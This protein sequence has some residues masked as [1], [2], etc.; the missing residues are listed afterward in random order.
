MRTLLI[1]FL[2]FLLYGTT[3]AAPSIDASFGNIHLAFTVN[4]GQSP[5]SIRFTAQGSG[6][7]M[8]FSPAGT[9]F[10]LSRETAA[11]VAKRAAKKSV[12]FENDPTRDRPEYE[13]FALK[14]AFVG[15]NENPEIQGEDRLPWNNNYFI[16]NDPDQWR[17]DVP[18]YKK[19]RLREVYDGVDLVYYGNRKRVKYDFVVKPGEDPEKILLKYDF[20]EAGGALEVNEKGE[21]VVKTPVGELIEEKPYCYQ[22]IEG[23]EAAVEVAYEVIEGGTYR[24]RVGEY[25]KSAELVIDPELVYSTYLGG[26]EEDYVD[27]IAADSEGCAYVTG[28]TGSRDFPITAGAYDTS[29]HTL[30]VSKL[31]PEGTALLYSTYL[32]GPEPSHLSRIAVDSQGNACVTG[33]GTVGFPVTENAIDKVYNGGDGFITKIN[34]TGNGLIVSTFFGGSQ[35]DEIEAVA[36]DHNDNIYITGYTYSSDFPTTPEAYENENDHGGGEVVFV[37]KFNSDASEVLYSTFIGHGAATDIQVNSSGEVY[38]CGR[39]RLTSPDYPLTDNAIDTIP[40]SIGNDKIFITKLNETGSQLVYSTLLGGTEDQ[41]S[42]GIALD[43]SGSAYVCG[44]TTSVDF[45]TT[46][47]AFM[48]GSILSR[49]YGFVSKISSDGGKLEYSTLLTGEKDTTASTDT[50]IRDI[51]IYG[52]GYSV[53]TGRTG[54]RYF[55]VTP[56][57]IQPEKKG[58][59]SI[60]AIISKDGGNLIYSTYWGGSGNDEANALALDG[61]GNVYIAGITSSVDFPRSEGAIDTTLSRYDYLR[62]PEGFTSKFH[63]GDIST[64]VSGHGDTP[65]KFHIISTYPNPFNPSTTIEFSLPEPEKVNLMVYSITGQKVY[66]V[67][68]KKLSAGTQRIR[69]DGKDAFN[70]TVSSGIYLIRLDN[71]KRSIA[72][73]VLFLK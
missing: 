43:S 61:I 12:V 9:T 19:I 71:G 70:K 45:P 67:Q 29:F 35:T 23:K 6:C 65:S 53:I 27:D 68:T 51:A 52:D 15:A 59:N 50:V 32:G 20:G 73:K 64:H 63:F 8:A 16:G 36:L 17:T 56:D 47:N 37:T 46:P 14:L 48:T 40:S 11:S 57:A 69:W 2:G 72:Q 58:G 55:P 39:T 7:G 1:A 3:L 24:F 4:R 33:E 31:N 26:I 41:A 13:S 28:I 60:L 30:F 10:L 38:I 54:A 21:L 22:K 49:Y 18:N 44:T 66:E 25:D 34:S 62:M 42:L 5:S